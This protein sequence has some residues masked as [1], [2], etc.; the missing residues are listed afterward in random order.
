MKMFC[1]IITNVDDAVFLRP[2]LREY[3]RSDERLFDGISIA[4]GNQRWDGIAEDAEE[5]ER[6]CADCAACDADLVVVTR[7]DVPADRDP[8][9]A[10][11]VKPEM[12]WEAHARHTA[13]QALR[14]RWGAEA[15]AA[16]RVLFLDSDEVLDAGK[17]R[18][19]AE[20][21]DARGL[22]A[23]KL[24][25]YWYWR[26]PTLRARA[27][28]EDSAILVRG[29]RISDDALYSDLGRHGLFAHVQQAGGAVARAVRGLDGRP[30]L[31]HY[32]WV[33]TREAML[34]KVAAWGH[35]SDREDW[36]ELVEREF[37]GPFR[38]TDF[39]KGLTYE[40]VPN[41]FGIDLLS[42]R[43]STAAR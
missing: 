8:A 29:G 26:E 3:T 18:A 4:V 24:A 38:G 19:F 20:C 7:Y 15:V 28:F 21:A 6:L 9:R 32:S 27:F 40:R 34:R 25:N 1:V 42:T 16:A 17:F 35:R 12:Y 11:C 39:L 22:D 23:A 33:R 10:A 37:S 41:H 5:L 30:M 13:L 2:A 36:A 31:H 43:G 14:Q